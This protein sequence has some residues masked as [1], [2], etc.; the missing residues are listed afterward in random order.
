M[1]HKK[2][3][4]TVVLNRKILT[5]CLVTTQKDYNAHYTAKASSPSI[6]VRV[7][8]EIEKESNGAADGASGAGAMG[9]GVSVNQQ[10]GVDLPWTDP[11]IGLHIDTMMKQIKK[12]F[13]DVIDFEPYEDTSQR[14]GVNK[15][16]N[17]S[18]FWGSQSSVKINRDLQSFAYPEAV[19]RETFTHGGKWLQSL[20]LQS[21]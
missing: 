15:P 18:A 7:K 19:S 10:A 11:D 1:F 17:I 4:R 21:P 12:E 9:A 16:S 8:A 5:S 3:P 14:K 6:G 2:T 20:I 13:V